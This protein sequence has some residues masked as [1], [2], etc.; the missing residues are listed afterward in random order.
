MFR[1]IVSL[2]AGKPMRYECGLDGCTRVLEA[3]NLALAHATWVHLAFVEREKVRSGPG[4]AG[5]DVRYKLRRPS[6]DELSFAKGRLNRNVGDLK[7]M[8]LVEE[9]ESIL[10][11][12]YRNGEAS[13]S[14]FELGWA[15]AIKNREECEER[16]KNKKKLK[17][18][19][20]EQETVKE[21]IKIAKKKVSKNS[22]QVSTVTSENEEEPLVKKGRGRPK[23]ST[24]KRVSS[25]ET[26]SEREEN[27]KFEMSKK[28]RVKESRTSSLRSSRAVSESKR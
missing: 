26:D 25:D 22:A 8:D 20:K 4:K 15:P 14:S 10:D 23:G 27:S 5:V 16:V 12:M 11:Q 9:A 6:P 28:S 2:K 19:E 13:M 7:A 21:K 3:Y 18:L 24:S 1:E 17:E